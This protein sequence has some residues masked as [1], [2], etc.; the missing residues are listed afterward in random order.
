MLAK[1]ELRKAVPSDFKKSKYQ[2]KLGQPY[3][4]LD[5]DHHVLI[6][7]VIKRDLDVN[8]FKTFLEDGQVY[9]PLQDYSLKEFLKD[10]TDD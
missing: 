1:I 9:V 7:D 8:I 6:Y 3:L 5:K 2:L 10:D 4:I